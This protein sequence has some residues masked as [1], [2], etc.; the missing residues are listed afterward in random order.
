MTIATRKYVQLA[1]ASLVSVHELFQAPQDFTVSLYLLTDQVEKPPVEIPDFVNLRQIP[2]RDWPW[3]TLAKFDDMLNTLETEIHC[4]TFAY[5][6][7]AD[8]RFVQNVTL[9][10]IRGL[11]VGV[12]HPYYP[13]NHLG[14]CGRCTLQ[15]LFFPL[16][17]LFAESCFFL[18]DMV[19][20]LRQE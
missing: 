9:E 16:I 4:S 1:V 20:F 19:M 8:T 7:D 15:L 14:F 3:S 2:D 13:R 5:F 17:I 12:E 10:D 18:G 11:L 6:L